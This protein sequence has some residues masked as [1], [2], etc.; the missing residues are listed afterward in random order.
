MANPN[1]MLVIL[2]AFNESGKIGRVVEKLK[3]VNITDTILTVDDYSSDNTSQEAVNAGAEVIRHEKNRGVGAAIRSGINYG[4]E[5]DFGIDVVMSGDD[6]HE[7]QEL[8]QV[9]EPIVTGGY[10]FIQ[11]SRRMLGGRVVNDRLFRKITTQL[12]SL[13][14]SLLAGR[15][16]TDATNGFRAFR[17]SIFD[18]KEINIAQEWLDRYELE[19]YIL[20]GVIKDKH[21]RFKEMPIT[22]Y[23]HQDGR[24][25]TKLFDK[26]VT[27]EN[28][29]RRDIDNIRRRVLSI[30]KMR[31]RLR[32]QP[33]R[34]LRG[35][36]N[37]TI[38]WYKSAQEKKAH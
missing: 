2:P 1:R 19:P 27:Y 34:T 16:V 30:E 8:K 20:Y 29:D 15:R 35:G 18:K 37:R 24:K 38:K 25:F 10:D 12:Y 3:R 11:G 33:Q 28:I 21:I 23:Y 14:F 4:L 22:I 6:Q 9:I 7:P 31:T 17:L 13:L 32:W 36:L 5:N 26:K